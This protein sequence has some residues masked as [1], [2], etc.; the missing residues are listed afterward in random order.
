[1]VWINDD[2]I[3]ILCGAKPGQAKA[4]SCAQISCHIQIWFGIHLWC[5]RQGILSSCCH[6]DPSGSSSQDC[7]LFQNL[8]LDFTRVFHETSCERSQSRT[9]KTSATVTQP[10]TI[11]CC[12]K[13]C[14]RLETNTSS[15]L[16]TLSSFQSLKHQQTRPQPDHP[17]RQD[18][19]DLQLHQGGHWHLP[20]L[21]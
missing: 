21:S 19:R 5:V 11:Q 12:L 16:L 6:R 20:L 8:S 10:S 2:S 9:Q 4:G 13:Q 15:L 18:R 3:W 1:M 14:L 17:P 7:V